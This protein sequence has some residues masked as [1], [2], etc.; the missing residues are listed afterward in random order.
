MDY[1]CHSTVRWMDNNTSITGVGFTK[2]T[3]KMRVMRRFIFIVHFRPILK[4]MLS[5]I[6]RNKPVQKALYSFIA[7]IS[8]L[9]VNHCDNYVRFLFLG[10]NMVSEQALQV[11]KDHEA[12]QRIRGGICPQRQHHRPLLAR[13][14]PALGGFRGEQRSTNVPKQLYEQFWT[15]VSKPPPSSG[16]DAQ[17]S[18]DVSGVFFGPQPTVNSVVSHKASSHLSQLTWTSVCVC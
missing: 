18:D 13:I 11:Q 9:I 1:M 6:G 4:S 14:A 17:A 8:L 12:W 3:E 5:L 2:T 10:E 16:R 7:L 15:L